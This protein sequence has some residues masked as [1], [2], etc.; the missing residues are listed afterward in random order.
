MFGGDEVIFTGQHKGLKL[1]IAFNLEGKQPTEVA[2]I[3]AYLCEQIE[4]F[5]YEFA[6]IDTKKIDSFAK[7]GK[8]IAGVIDF[9]TSN[10]PGQIKTK[11][12]EALPSKIESK[13]TPSQLMSIADSYLINRLFTNA[14]VKFK[15]EATKVKPEKEKI[16]DVIAFIGKYKEWVAIKKLGIEKVKDYEVSGILSGIENTIV[17]KSFELAEMQNESK[18]ATA[19]KSYT[20]LAEALK[21][22]PSNANPCTIC[23]TCEAVG[24]KPYASPELLTNAYPDIKPPKVKGRRPL[25]AKAVKAPIVADATIGKPKG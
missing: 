9:L 6:G 8:G 12:A 14:G 23:K 25:P 18:T 11:L 15:I 4:P 20:N 17:N 13:E 21:Q 3:L 1:G 7:C 2:G 24:Y 10:S 16:E 19:R 22:L 5:A